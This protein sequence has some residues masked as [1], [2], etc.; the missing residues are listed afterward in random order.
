LYDGWL[1]C[2]SFVLL[3]IGSSG[4][5]AALAGLQKIPWNLPIAISR[6]LSDLF[7]IILWKP[8]TTASVPTADMGFAAS[9]GE[10]N[11][12]GMVGQS[13]DPRANGGGGEQVE[14]GDDVIARKRRRKRVFASVSVNTCWT[15]PPLALRPGA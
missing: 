12:S 11:S 10:R 1:A 7:Q 9:N 3:G 5:A 13:T 4:I 15:P 2:R 6:N 8:S 14:A